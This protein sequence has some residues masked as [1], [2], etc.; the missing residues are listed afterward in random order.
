MAGLTA[1]RWAWIGLLILCYLALCVR[2]AMRM[3]RTGRNFWLWLAISVFFTS[4]PGTFV[5]MQ[6]QIRG[7]SKAPSRRAAR[8]GPDAE[9]IRCDQCG[10]PLRP[11][12]VDHSGGL[13]TCPHCGLPL[14]EAK[15]A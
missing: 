7:M 13:A 4:I 10:Q 2:T 6:D 3:A 9:R 15:H 1:T 12:D 8:R 14:D 11:A 5:L